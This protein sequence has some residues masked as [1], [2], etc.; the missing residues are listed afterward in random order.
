MKILKTMSGKLG[1]GALLCAAC[2]ALPLLGLLG[3]SSAAL[4]L[5]F[6]KGGSECLLIA[7][8]GLAGI[9]LWQRR[10]RQSGPASCKTSCATDCECS[11]QAAIKA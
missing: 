4:G 11:N 2:C 5:S 8:L 9:L 3:G 6:L 7:G 1:L 10:R